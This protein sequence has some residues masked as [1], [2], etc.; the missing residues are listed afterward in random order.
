[1]IKEGKIDKE[2]EHS[3]SKTNQPDLAITTTTMTPDRSSD[4]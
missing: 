4:V 3:E 2:C 1:M